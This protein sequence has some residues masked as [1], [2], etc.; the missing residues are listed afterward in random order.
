MIESTVLYAFLIETPGTGILGF[1]QT[2]V[3]PASQQELEEKIRIQA[4][5]MDAKV[6][7]IPPQEWSPPKLNSVSQQELT[8][9][10]PQIFTCVQRSMAKLGLPDMDPN[11]L[12]KNGIVM[13]NPVS[14][15]VFFVY[16]VEV[17]TREKQPTADTASKDEQLE[18]ALSLFN[19]GFELADSGQDRA[20]FD[21]YEKAMIH[22]ER[23]IDT[24]PQDVEAYYLKAVLTGEL[25]RL[26]FQQRGQVAGMKWPPSESLKAMKKFLEVAP[27]GYDPERVEEF[28]EHVRKYS[29]LM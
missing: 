3:F 21:C 27:P 25:G 10:F 6:V 18:E 9:K 24:N 28:Q 29:D 1:G 20:A 8:A 16:K 4:N 15:K 17:A 14:G 19:K 12:L 13:P 2:V 5:S 7:I 11:E 23:V 22:C 26:E